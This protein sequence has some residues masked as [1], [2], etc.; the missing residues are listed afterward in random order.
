MSKIARKQ[1]LM[2][3]EK[4]IIMNSR[5]LR[6]EGGGYRESGTKNE[7]SQWLRSC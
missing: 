2:L 3:A 6:L 4:L 7:V 1:I 5:E